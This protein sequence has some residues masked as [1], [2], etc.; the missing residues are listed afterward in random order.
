MA[1]ARTSHH[2]HHASGTIVKVQVQAQNLMIL[3]RK[4]EAVSEILATATYVVIYVFEP[5][6]KQWERKEVR[7]RVGVG[8]TTAIRH[9]VV[10]PFTLVSTYIFLL[11]SSIP[12]SDRGLPLRREAF[13]RGALPPGGAEPHQPHGPRAGRMLDRLGRQGETDCII[14]EPSVWPELN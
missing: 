1:H 5:K 6:G 10:R 12:C 2:A 11:S 7:A 8:T 3:Q 9:S 14:I 13:L 4:D